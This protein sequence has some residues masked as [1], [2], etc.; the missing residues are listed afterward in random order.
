L[1][2]HQQA[3]LMI[4]TKIEMVTNEFPKN[5]QYL[6]PQVSRRDNIRDHLDEE[7]LSSRKSSLKNV[8]NS[9]VNLFFQIS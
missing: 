6:I 2:K 7:M 5:K 8:L 1:A 9:Q 4:S 3:N